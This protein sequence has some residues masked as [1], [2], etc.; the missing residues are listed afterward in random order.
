MRSIPGVPTSPD[1]YAETR[2][3][4]YLGCFISSRKRVRLPPPILPAYALKRYG[5]ASQQQATE[6]DM[7]NGKHILIDIGHARMTGASAHGWH[8]HEEM[9]AFAPVLAE[10]LQA[11]GFFSSIIDYPH[12]SNEADLVATVKEANSLRP[13]FIL[14][15]HMDCSE[16][17]KARGGHVCY[18]SAKGERMARCIAGYLCDLFPGRAEQVVKRSGLYVLRKTYAPAVLIE[19]C[20]ISHEEDMAVFHRHK[21][22]VAKAIA[23][24]VCNYFTA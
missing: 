23:Q 24:G 16:N 2:E 13:D 4:R 8:E 5:V 19:C 1:G 3:K 20:F 17:E 12:L 14:S 15:L 7:T 9:E 10:E 18:T 21:K 6:H 11:L 22:M